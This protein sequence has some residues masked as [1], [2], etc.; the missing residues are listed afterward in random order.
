[1]PRDF[2]V[3]Y[4][5][6]IDASPYGQ[7]RCCSSPTT[8][9]CSGSRDAASSDSLP[10]VDLGGRGRSRIAGVPGRLAPLEPRS[11]GSPHVSVRMRVVELSGTALTG[12]AASG[13]VVAI[14]R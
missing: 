5:A 11:F 2:V 14:G 7:L 13:A 4:A 9:S 1:M 10:G 12:S 6:W 8:L 3:P